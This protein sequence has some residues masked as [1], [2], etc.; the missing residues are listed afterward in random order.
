VVQDYTFSRKTYLQPGLQPTF[1]RKTYR[2]PEL[3]PFRQKN[4]SQKIFFYVIIFINS[5][6]YCKKYKPYLKHVIMKIE[7]IKT[8]QMRND[9]YFQFQTEF[10]DLIIKISP[11]KLKVTKQFNELYM[12]LYKQ[13]DDILKKIVKSALTEK[14]Q[15]ADAMRDDMCI[16]INEIS[17]AHLR[18]FDPATCDAAKRVRIVMDTY[19]NI[20]RKPLHEQTSAVYN[21]LQELQGEYKD[22]IMKIGLDTWVAKLQQTNSELDALVKGRYEEAAAK[23]DAV[24]RDTRR[25]LDSIY[26]KLREIINVFATIENDTDVLNTFIKTFNIVI[27]KYAAIMAQQTG[28]KIKPNG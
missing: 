19:G 2:Q 25:E 16:G 12:P 22:D 8:R 5:R 1:S 24:M 21:L 17:K 9:A 11:D 26:N 27:G 15:E 10:K 3:L 6:L 20:A 18:H 23:T 28:K 4:T 7:G 13:V 14:I